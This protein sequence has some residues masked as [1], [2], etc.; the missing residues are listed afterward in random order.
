MKKTSLIKGL[1]KLRWLTKD[2]RFKLEYSARMHRRY[3]NISFRVIY[4]RA[5]MLQ[6]SVIQ[7]RSF[8]EN[9]ATKKRLTE[10]GHETF[11][12]ILGGRKLH[13]TASPYNF[14]DFLIIHSAKDLAPLIDEHFKTRRAFLDFLEQLGFTVD[15]AVLSVHINGKKEFTEWHKMAYSFALSY[16]VKK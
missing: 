13:I 15:E 8:H 12:F 6:I 7:G 3:A 11:D 16:Y 9:Y 10:I 5:D 14:K 1:V 4:V 2:Q